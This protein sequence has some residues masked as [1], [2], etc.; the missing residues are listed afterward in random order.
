MSYIK[1]RSHRSE[2][3]VMEIKSHLLGQLVAGEDT[4]HVYGGCI[5]KPLW[6]Q[7]DTNFLPGWK[8]HTKKSLF[9]VL[10]V[11]EKKINVSYKLF[12]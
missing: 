12:I 8:K 4:I 1:G 3:S 7:Q 5:K 9:L 6:T 2:E 10:S 11:Q